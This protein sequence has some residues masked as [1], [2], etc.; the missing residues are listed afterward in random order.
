MTAIG[1]IEIL[2][3][4]VAVLAVTKPVGAYLVRVFDGSVRWLAP[5]ER[6]IYRAC[7]IDPDEEQHWTRYAAGLLLFSAVSMLVTYVA[8]RLQAHLPLNPFHRAAVPDRQAFEDRR[9]G[10]YPATRR[11]D[12]Y[13]QLPGFRCVAVLCA[14]PG[15]GSQPGRTD[16]ECLA[17]FLCRRE[18]S[19]AKHLHA[20]PGT[21]REAW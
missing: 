14:E 9:P 11:A 10:A 8:L 17:G 6:L 1:W 5:L 7:G 21:R 3:F 18:Q 15:K 4:S 19:G 13:A 2:V 16:K 20:A 12:Y